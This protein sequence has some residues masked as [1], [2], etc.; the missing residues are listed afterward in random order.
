MNVLSVTSTDAH[1]ASGPRPSLMAGEESNSMESRSAVS[2]K[3]DVFPATPDS[4][5]VVAVPSTVSCGS[6]LTNDANPWQPC[7]APDADSGPGN[8]CR[9]RVVACHN[10]FFPRLVSVLTVGANFD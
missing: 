2:T 10:A 6:V 4:R 9:R 7:Y 8:G 1:K 3:G 5:R